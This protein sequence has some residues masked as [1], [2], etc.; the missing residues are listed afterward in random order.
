MNRQRFE[1]I[2]TASKFRPLQRVPTPHGA[3]LLAESFRCLDI[4]HMEP[5]WQML[6]AIDRDGMD[7]ARKI[8]CVPNSTREQRVA[9]TIADAVRFISDS[10]EA[11]R[12]G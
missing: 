1:K 2:V 7:I 4:N 12:Y 5:H 9:A 11:G 3:I 6:W 10:I 8:Y